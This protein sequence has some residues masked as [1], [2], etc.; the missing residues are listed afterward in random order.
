MSFQESTQAKSDMQQK[1]GMVSADSETR[2]AELKAKAHTS[3]S[4]ESIS[5]YFTIAAAGFGLI[6]DGYQNNLMTMANVI[7]KQLYPKE[8]TASVSTRVS[9]ALLVGKFLLS[10]SWRYTASYFHLRSQALFS[11]RYLSGWFAIALEE[12]SLWYRLLF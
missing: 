8:Y 5:A 12:R 1:A 3:N 11:D 6:S 4:K 10:R 9:N 2:A 7:F